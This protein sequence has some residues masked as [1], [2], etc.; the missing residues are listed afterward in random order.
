MCI[1]DRLGGC[2]GLWAFGFSI[3]QLS[4]FAMVV[5]IGILVDDAIVVVENVERIMAEEG[6]S[7]ARATIKAMGQIRGAIIGITAV[8]IAVFLPMAFFPGSTGGI[9]RQ[10]SLTIV[11]TMVL[12]VF[13][14][15]ILSPAITATLLKRPQDEDHESFVGRNSARRRL[16]FDRDFSLPP[17]CATG[18][19]GRARPPP[20]VGARGASPARPATS[21]PWAAN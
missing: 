17:Q 4:L 13:V 6:L 20:A 8:L 3:N 11:S 19:G 1:R 10:F 16:W 14:A 2:L 12:S 15:L 18:R 7:P 21:A 9:Y 5:A